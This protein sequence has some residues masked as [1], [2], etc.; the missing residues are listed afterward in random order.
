MFHHACRRVIRSENVFAPWSLAIGLARGRSW[1]KS[2]R[3]VAHMQVALR[4][5]HF[6][7]MLAKLRIDR[8]IEVAHH[9]QTLVLIRAGNDAC[10]N[11]GQR[12]ERQA[13]LFLAARTEHRATGDALFLAGFLQV[14]LGKGQL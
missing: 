5:R 12:L 3:P 13:A 10:K 7:R 4:K 1:R 6:D 9:L 8:E 14:D 2:G 11:T